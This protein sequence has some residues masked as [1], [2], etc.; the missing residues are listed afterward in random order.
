MDLPQ[1][2]PLPQMPGV[3]D[4]AAFWPPSLAHLARPYDTGGEYITLAEISEA[5]TQG[6]EGYQRVA[7]GLVPL[8]DV[9]AL[10]Q[11]AAGS[12]DAVSAEGPLPCVDD[13]GP[14]HRS[15]FWIDGLTRA[16]R[17]EPLVNAWKGSDAF[18]LVPDN[19]LL[20]VF[21][22]VPRQTGQAQMSWDDV[23]GP[24]YDVV[25]VSSVWDHQR[26]KEQRQRAFVE[27]RRDYLLEYCRIKQ[28]AAVAFFFEERYSE[29]DAVFDR[30]LADREGEDFHLPGRL[31]CL[32]RIQHSPDDPPRQLAQVWGRRMVVPK[33]ERRVLD[34]QDPALEWPD[35]DGLM[36]LQ[37][38]AKSGLMAYVRDQVLLDY[39]GRSVFQIHP[40]SGAVSYRGQW[41]VS[42]CHRVGRNHIALELKKLYEGS[43]PPV[44]EHW[45][46]HAVAK[47]KAAIDELDGN[48]NIAVRAEEL[49]LAHLG[50]TRSL[51]QLAD[52]LGLAFS[53][54]DIGGFEAKEVEHRGWW[55]TDGLSSLANIALLDMPLD[56]FLDRA[57][58]LVVLWESIQ[59][60]PLRNMV[61][62]L[63]I[64]R[65]KLR[66]FKSMKLL[67]AVCQLATACRDA[68]HRWP[69]DAEYVV[70]GWNHETKIPAL[71][72][73]FAIN[74]LR[75]KAAHRTGAGFAESLTKD[76][77]VFGIEQTAQAAGWGR[78]VDTLYD[79]LIEDF[80]VI[81]ALLQVDD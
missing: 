79:G 63:G 77:V 11:S 9:D 40:P 14:P 15:G 71:Q 67:A 72:R 75:I 81:A 64:E 41:S 56:A 5:P 39:E 7:L 68:G 13:D 27:I 2:P 23:R 78:A 45:H 42:F 8:A 12:G 21:G 70:E 62:Q 58:D 76:L 60:A 25:K 73:L 32:K 4:P 20:M 47:A 28:A 19:N 24:V 46:R 1:I 16:D 37:R 31:L 34:V 65:E 10:L 49:V 43:P 18:V 69:R 52:R 26:P 6:F 29:G 54:I 38:A 50:L 35:H 36:S 33:G 53:E 22:L 48:R 61:A 3:D 44:I 57:V 59:E 17:F 55:T 51:V 30:V 80:K 74:Q 66:N